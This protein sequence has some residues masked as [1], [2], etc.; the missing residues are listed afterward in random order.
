ML[1]VSCHRNKLFGCA[2][3]VALSMCV[4]DFSIHSSHKKHRITS[5]Y[6]ADTKNR[7]TTPGDPVDCDPRCQLEWLS[8]VGRYTGLQ[9]RL[10]VLKLMGSPSHPEPPGRD[11]I[12]MDPPSS[13]QRITMGESQG[14]YLSPWNIFQAEQPRARMELFLFGRWSASNPS[15]W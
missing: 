5:P 13:L 4:S 11:R 7:S 6:S 14:T 8:T 1:F 10:W 9:A 2:F 15:R 3:C 12:T